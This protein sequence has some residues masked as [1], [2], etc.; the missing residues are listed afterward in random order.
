MTNDPHD[1]DL[2]DDDLHWDDTLD[3]DAR[4][5]GATGALPAP[6]DGSPAEHDDAWE[7]PSALDAVPAPGRPVRGHGD[8]LMLLLRLVGPDRAGPPALW[9]VVLDAHDRTVPVVLPLA[10][11]PLTASPGVAAHVMH[12][13][14]SVLER[15]APGGSVLVGLVRAAGG[16]RGTFETSWAPALRA[17][18]D[19]H[20]VRLHAVAAIGG[21]RA[22]VIEW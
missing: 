14:A 8:A 17:A 22:R 13:L 9:F 20:G 12:V 10:D 18:A 7:V 3:D 21:S 2:H 1:D 11:V 5:D 19:D 15:D 16:D 4:A 6:D